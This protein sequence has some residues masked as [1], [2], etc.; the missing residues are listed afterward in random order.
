MMTK[1]ETKKQ[2]IKPTFEQLEPRLLLSSD[3]VLQCDLDLEAASTGVSAIYAPVTPQETITDGSTTVNVGADGE[4]QVDAEG[5][6]YLLETSYSYPKIVFP[7]AP[8]PGQ[9]AG[10]NL[11]EGTGTVANDSVGVPP[12]NGII[13]GG[14]WV[15]DVGRSVLDF[16][17]INDEVNAGNSAA[18]DV[19]GTF[20][21]EAWMKPTQTGGLE[22]GVAGKDMG[23]FT[24]AYNN[25]NNRAYW[26]VAHGA[27]NWSTVVTTDAWNH[28][29]GT[30]DGTN[31]EL[32]VNGI[33]SGTKLSTHTPLGAGGDFDIGFVEGLPGYFDG[34]IANVTLYDRA[35]T[36]EEVSTQFAIG[37]GNFHN[38]VIEWNDLVESPAD[39]EATWDPIITKVNATKV[40]IAAAG[41]YYSLVRTVE[42]V[43]GKVTFNDELTNTDPSDSIGILT[44]TTI[45]TDEGVYQDLFAPAWHRITGH[46]SPGSKWEAERSSNPTIFLTGTDG[47]LGVLLEDNFGRRH[48]Y[49]ET[50]GLPAG[51]A[52]F[53]F[54]DLALAGGN[55][56]T[57]SWTLYPLDNTTD[58]FDFYNEVRIDWNT[59]FEID[60]PFAFFHPMS[61]G[62]ENHIPWQDADELKYHLEH[63]NLGI[64]AVQPFLDYDPGNGPGKIWTRAEY[65][66]NVTPIIEAFDAADPEVK[67]VGLVE[68]DW[69]AID[70]DSIT[71]GNLL[72]PDSPVGTPWLTDA[73]SQIIR[74][75]IAA[76]ELPN[77]NAT[78][79]YSN[80]LKTNE[81][82]N[83]KVEIW[84]RD[85]G[86]SH[87]MALAV[88]PEV[89]NY[90]Y[91][92]L[93]D[94]VDF[95]IST[96]DMDGVYFDQF[97]MVHSG[98]ESYEDGLG[99]PQT[100]GYTGTVNPG[101]G[102]IE[103]S[104]ERYDANLAGISARVNLMNSITGVGKTVVANTY[105]SS[106]EEQA[107]EV[108][109]F[110][111]VWNSFDV[112]GAVPGPDPLQT[113]SYLYAGALASPIAVGFQN[114]YPELGT[115]LLSERA[116]SLSN[117]IIGYLKHGLLYYHL[118]GWQVP[119]NSV[120]G[121]NGDY[122]HVNN[123]FQIT[124][125][126]LHEGWIVGQERTITTVSGDF[127]W[128]GVSEP[129]VLVFD[130]DGR[131]STAS[132]SF[133]LTGSPG[134]WNVSLTI[135][136]WDDI[137]VIT[138]GDNKNLTVAATP[139]EADI[140][141]DLE[142][143]TPFTVERADGTSTTLIAD[144]T[145][146][147]G[148]TDYFFSR[149]VLE[150]DPG[151]VAGY[152]M[153]KPEGVIDTVLDDPF[154]RVSDSSGFN[155]DGSLNGATW[156]ND[157]DAQRW[158]LEFDGVND[159]V[160]VGNSEALNVTDAFSV[161]LW[162][163]PDLS[164]GGLSG[165]AGKDMGRFSLAYLNS[166]SRLFWFIGAGANSVS[167][168]VTADEW[169]HVVA[170]FD[171][172]TMNL[173]V[174]D[175]TPDSKTSSFASIDTGGDLDI[176]FIETLG[177]FEGRLA[178]VKFY[179]RALSAS[180][181]STQYGAGVVGWKDRDERAVAQ[182]TIVVNL[183]EH[184]TAVAE[185]G[186]SIP[187]DF[188]NDMDVDG[189][190]KALWEAS[191]G[192][193]DGADADQDGD[194]DGHDFMIW[195]RNLGTVATVSAAHS[196]AQQSLE[197]GVNTVT[198]S[199]KTDPLVASSVSS[200]LGSTERERPLLQQVG[201]TSLD[202]ALD[203]WN[204]PRD[205]AAHGDSQFG[206]SNFGTDIATGEASA[207]PARGSSKSHPF[208]FSTPERRD[209]D[210]TSTEFDRA[211]A[212]WTKWSLLDEFLDE[213]M[214]YR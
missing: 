173:Y 88:Y 74:D 142:A 85:G 63:R 191:Y 109:R 103:L 168:D 8:I 156:V 78:G 4:L 79:G 145:V 164:G 129:R 153:D 143:K 203:N 122:G 43:D 141:G 54:N 167:Q 130:N 98:S 10:W 193:D 27:N 62:G 14:A 147:D 136:D 198:V 107:L 34:Q 65:Q 182:T 144:A 180:E 12:Q 190:D 179:D 84:S 92:F 148:L 89:G 208:D 163:K 157:V 127:Q 70:R 138:S 210:E 25:A 16:D 95:L 97:S 120:D 47:N 9:V 44:D 1:Q 201:L 212:R 146:T 41:A 56:Q 93:Q 160:N 33:S 17:G 209:A 82:G 64:V 39:N 51:E 38:A 213:L 206:Q 170:T 19:V 86:T 207:A 140:T 29:V 181:V 42:I 178:D 104:S 75:A 154:W 15:T 117:A 155:Q 197:V 133:T 172:S 161:A 123:M 171:G 50:E 115:G 26:Y 28:V 57:Y 119:E 37:I 159:E 102:Q 110:S 68:T 126:E 49:I 187:G 32:F 116:E 35:L 131:F 186:V 22:A 139:F 169:N 30:Y 150:T 151:L 90:Q 200:S 202:L 137:A 132:S 165:V 125:V 23:R 11:D 48:H 189:D 111:E 124:P 45:S 46:P 24:L 174:N 73:Q 67:L 83:F 192:V 69:Y 113:V 188:D 195:Q 80:S 87:Y 183:D 105:S 194:S 6:S 96:M 2:Q 135:Q 72:P 36:A 196:A 71:N 7:G 134:A 114:G 53:Q 18:L 77:L 176:G 91:E 152:K 100:D 101:T 175:G 128:T 60:G 205:D 20:S 112:L 149:W 61:A 13:T 211:L 66:T 94:Q 59:N 121:G 81:D 214:P 199:A 52:Y 106:A 76:G 21:V 184:T 162:M 55:S 31:I 177:H 99:N 58:K 185:Y 5:V 3:P 118:I 166:T 158:A 40:T 204:S 108:N